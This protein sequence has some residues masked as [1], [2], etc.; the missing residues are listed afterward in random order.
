MAVPYTF[1]TATSS[2]PLSQ[3]DTNFATAI[4]LGNTAVYLGNTVTSLGNVTL[5]NPTISGGTITGVSVNNSLTN[6]SALR[7][8]TASTYTSNTVFIEGYTNIADGGGGTFMYVSTDTTSSDNN[9]TIIVDASSRRW[10]RQLNVGYTDVRWF[11]YIAD[12]STD[13]T[14]AINYALAALPSSG[15]EIV[16]PA[17]VGKVNSAITYNFSASTIASISFLGCGADVTTILFPNSDGFIV[18]ADYAKQSVHFR[19]MTITTST[20]NAHNGITLINS[21]LEGTFAQSDITRVTLR[22]SDGGQSTYYWTT[23]INVVGLSNINYVG[24]LIYGNSTGNGTGIAILGNASTSPYYD[25]VQN[26][27]QCGFFNLGIGLNYGTYLQGVSVSQCNFTNGVTGIYLGLTE[28]GLAQLTVTAS[29]FNTT[30]NQISVQ[31]SIASIIL[32]SNLFYVTSGNAGLYINATGTQHTIVNNVFTA[33][34]SGN[35]KG[36][37]VNAS[38]IDCVCTS[39]VFYNLN[40]GVDLVGTSTWNVQA[41]AYYGTTTQVANIGSNSVGVATK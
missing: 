38:N 4:T 18:N 16:F 29:Q 9:G 36:I 22:G 17:G 11:G 34:S 6:I 21:V 25:I 8:A 33:V 2:I 30:A 19:D 10:Y 23:A 13:N 32:N 28:T 1:A 20:S 3:L 37:L 5:I 35:G 31:S 7:S 24:L 26:L 15:G 12:G 41:N 39:N 40:T 27:T 14:N